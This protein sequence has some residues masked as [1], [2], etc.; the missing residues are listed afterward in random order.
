ML[1]NGT[2]KT[3]IHWFFK[4]CQKYR[5]AEKD[6]GLEE[7]WDRLERC[8]NITTHHFTLDPQPVYPKSTMRLTKYS[9]L[10]LAHHHLNK[11]KR[12]TVQ[13]KAKEKAFED[14]NILF[15]KQKTMTG[16]VPYLYVCQRHFSQLKSYKLINRQCYFFLHRY[17]PTCWSFLTCFVIISDVKYL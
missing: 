12:F 9:F 5:N 3:R 6:A 11:Y 17:W 13:K 15:H 10:H 8:V 1:G 14:G 4:K 2:F 16:C 7:R